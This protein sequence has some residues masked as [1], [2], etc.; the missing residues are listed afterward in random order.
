LP[1]LR[2]IEHGQRPLT[3]ED[4]VSQAM[5][6]PQAVGASGQHDAQGVRIGDLLGG[7]HRFAVQRTRLVEL[8]E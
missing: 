2:A 4:H 3:G 6:A 5:R 8:L 7:R 1:A